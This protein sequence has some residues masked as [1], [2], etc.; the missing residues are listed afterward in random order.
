MHVHLEHG[1]NQIR[2][3]H[4]KQLLG[5]FHVSDRYKKHTVYGEV[6]LMCINTVI[7]KQYYYA[8]NVVTSRTEI[9]LIPIEGKTSY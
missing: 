4:N 7:A 3:P 8:R 6:E 1:T 5:V 9:F 2:H